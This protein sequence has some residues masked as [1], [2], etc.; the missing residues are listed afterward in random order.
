MVGTAGRRRKDK[1]ALAAFAHPTKLQQVE[2][3]IPARQS[4][5]SAALSSDVL[6]SDGSASRDADVDHR[7]SII[8]RVL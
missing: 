8:G 2:C 3:R 5:Y 1:D 7:C 4:P 6:T